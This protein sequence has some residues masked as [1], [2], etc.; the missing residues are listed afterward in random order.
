MI[1]I[2]NM[3]LFEGNKFKNTPKIKKNTINGYT[4]LYQRQRYNIY[5]EEK[6]GSHPSPL[7]PHL[8]TKYRIKGYIRFEGYKI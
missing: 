5:N 8:S 3:V 2:E 4:K 7:C 6:L 1:Y